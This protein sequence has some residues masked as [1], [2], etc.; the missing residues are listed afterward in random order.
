MRELTKDE[1]KEL[2]I[3]WQLIK[4]GRAPGQEEKGRAI[5]F[6]NKIAGTNYSLKSSCSSCLGAV[7]YG[8]E[9]LYNKYF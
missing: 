3:I 6:W 9:K 5:T 2:D 4:T 1:I 8:T 7:Y